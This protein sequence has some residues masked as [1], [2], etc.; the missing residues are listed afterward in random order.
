MAAPLQTFLFQHGSQMAGKPIGLIVSSASS[1]IS[2]VESDARRLIPGGD[3]FTPGLW[4]RSSQ[5]SNAASLISGWLETIHYSEL[6]GIDCLPADHNLASNTIYTLAGR[7]IDRN[8]LSLQ[9]L[10]SGL[11]IING[12]KTY[13]N[14]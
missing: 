12:N 2:S 5:T 13:L 9:S 14:N 1:G 10:E 4:I 7:L 11:Y 3:F 6:S 8:L